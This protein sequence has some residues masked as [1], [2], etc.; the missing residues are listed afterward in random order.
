[1][2]NI[3]DCIVT[4]FGEEVETK[5]ILN[6]TGTSSPLGSVALGNVC[7]NQAAHLSLLIEPHLAMFSR[8]NDAGNIGDGDSSFRDVSRL[9]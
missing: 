3:Y 7:L 8:I 9:Y 6:T 1:V 4:K 2:G 5:S